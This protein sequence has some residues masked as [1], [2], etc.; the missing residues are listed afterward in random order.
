MSS[1]A[2]S[3]CCSTGSGI[4]KAGP[5]VTVLAVFNAHHDAVEFTLPESPD[6]CGWNWLMDTNDP[7]LPRQLFEFGA[8]YMVTGRSMLLFERVAPKK[9]TQPNGA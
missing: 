8:V 5:E 3:A 1:R 2:A 7:D 6:S 4:K 9:K